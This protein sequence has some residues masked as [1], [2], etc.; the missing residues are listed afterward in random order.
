MS[1][2]QAGQERCQVKVFDPRNMHANMNTVTCI[3]LGTGKINIWGRDKQTK[4][5][6]K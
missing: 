2:S 1:A 3:N 6:T 5:Q 4:G